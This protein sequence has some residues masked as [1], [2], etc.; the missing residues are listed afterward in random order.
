[1][2]QEAAIRG[3]GDVQALL[4]E[5]LA[6]GPGV[7]GEVVQKVGKPSQGRE[8]SSQTSTTGT[9]ALLKISLVRDIKKFSQGTEKVGYYCA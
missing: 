7:W 2:A 9:A 1:M 4:L 3:Q 8:R 6:S 5:S